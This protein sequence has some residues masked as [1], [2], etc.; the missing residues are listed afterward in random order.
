MEADSFPISNA[1]GVMVD[2]E[3]DSREAVLK[4]EKLM[5]FTCWGILIGISWQ[6]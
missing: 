5:I 1:G 6:A 2:N 4:Q 3:G